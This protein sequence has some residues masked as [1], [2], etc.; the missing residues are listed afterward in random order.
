MFRANLR[1]ALA[2][3]VNKFLLQE[4]KSIDG[5]MNAR[6]VGDIFREHLST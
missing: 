6:P 2:I 5:D 3:R 1:A 4:Q